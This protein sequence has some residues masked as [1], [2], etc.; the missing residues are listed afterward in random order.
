LKYFTL[1]EKLS[2]SDKWFCPNCEDHI[3]AYKKLD[4][5]K[6]PKVLII[7]IKR[8]VWYN[9]YNNSKLNNTVQ[10]PFEGLDISEFVINPNEKDKKYKLV[11]VSTH[12][13]GL[14]GGHYTAYGLNETENN[15][16]Y[17]NDS[18][19]SKVNDLENIMSNAYVL[20]Y[21]QED[22]LSSFRS[23]FHS[24]SQETKSHPGSKSE[25]SRSKEDTKMKSED[26]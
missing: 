12:S 5:W 14:G 20:C 6:I 25:K 18:S 7:H 13:G 3:A 17:F 10:F 26:K 23:E 2:E 9:R 15:W 8:F 24:E 22:Y 21:V 4:I 1:N 11:G 16:Y 19:V